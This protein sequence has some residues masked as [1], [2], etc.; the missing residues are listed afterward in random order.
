MRA[1]YSTR[2]GGI[3]CVLRSNISE[4]KGWLKLHE[5]LGECFAVGVFDEND[6]TAPAMMPSAD[7]INLSVEASTVKRIKALE[8]AGWQGKEV[9]FY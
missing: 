7:K 9:E 4:C 2:Q 6:P 3:G 8:S 1:V 5:S